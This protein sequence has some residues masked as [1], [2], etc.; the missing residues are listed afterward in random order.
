MRRFFQD[1]MFLKRTEDGW[2]RFVRIPDERN[3]NGANQGR[4][5]TTPRDARREEE[6]PRRESRREEA[7]EEAARPKEEAPKE[8]EGSREG[9]GRKQEEADPRLASSPSAASSTPPLRPK[10]RRPM[11]IRQ[12]GVLVPRELIGVSSNQ[13]VGHEQS[14][15]DH[16]H[17]SRRRY[18]HRRRLS[19]VP[20]SSAIRSKRADDPERDDRRES[21]P[22]SIGDLQRRLQNLATSGEDDRPAFLL[23]DSPSDSSDPESTLDKTCKRMEK[24]WLGSLATD[25]KFEP[26]EEG[27]VLDMLKD[28]GSRTTT[29][30]ANSSTKA[31][32]G[33][34]VHG[35]GRHRSHHHVSRQSHGVEPPANRT[36][37]NTPTNQHADDAPTSTPSQRRHHSETQSRRL[38]LPASTAPP[39]PFP[40]FDHATW[41]ALCARDASLPLHGGCLTLERHGDDVDTDLWVGLADPFVL[42]VS[43]ATL[44]AHLPRIFG[45]L[46]RRNSRFGLTPNE[47]HPDVPRYGVSVVLEGRRGSVALRELGDLRG[48]GADVADRTGRGWFRADFGALIR[49][50]H[51]EEVED[52]AGFRNAMKRMARYMDCGEA[53]ARCLRGVEANQTAELRLAVE[54]EPCEYLRFASKYNSRKTFK[55]AFD[56]VAEQAVR[57]DE[58]DCSNFLKG[59][60][61]AAREIVRRKA[62]A[63]YKN[64][65]EDALWQRAWDALGEDRVLPSGPARG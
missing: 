16:E 39:S 30:D 14:R 33:S 34:S 5:R 57:R 46:L 64:I 49:G 65:E 63:F 61:S 31:N 36:T 42:S 37:P 52:V 2:Y 22:V 54:R 60:P 27:S 6:A 35:H 1:D 62:R 32:A 9:H 24:D 8:A 51:G 25:G 20:D 41:D 53:V 48:L 45:G 23:K 29:G 7:F 55:M 4:R 47:Q 18:H 43:S 19:A 56:V 26:W 15:P 58:P 59:V 50:V 11:R 12:V 38:R 10:A 28:D 44:L 13:N 3:T 40:V 21:S 17:R